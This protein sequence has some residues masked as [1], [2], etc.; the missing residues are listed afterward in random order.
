MKNRNVDERF[1]K[2]MYEAATIVNVKNKQ[3]IVQLVSV[4]EKLREQLADLQEFKEILEMQQRLNKLG[5][6]QN[7]I[8]RR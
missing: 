3:F 1:Y 4:N 5:N 6:K 8:E 7:F 2:T